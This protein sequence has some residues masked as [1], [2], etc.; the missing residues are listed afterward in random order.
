MRD[1]GLNCPNLG[2]HMLVFSFKNKYLQLFNNDAI[3][4][5]FAHLISEKLDV[6]GVYA[7]YD[8]LKLNCG[9]CFLQYCL[10]TS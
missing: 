3:L 2:S 9:I 8:E 4:V 1:S 6:T 10:I 5:S 7:Y